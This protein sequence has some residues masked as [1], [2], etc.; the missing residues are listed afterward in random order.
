[1][2]AQQ[3]MANAYQTTDTYSGVT[4]ADPHSLITQMFD[5]AVRKIAQARGA[6][7]RNDVASK[8]E[9]LSQSVAIIGSLEACLDKEK[10]GDLANNLSNLYEYMNISLALANQEND[11]AR[12]DEVIRLIQEIRSAW[13]QIPE[14]VRQE[15]KG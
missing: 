14:E 2:N 4:F 13:T 10:G 5:G 12:L 15:F 11:T 3:N 8:A 7:E 6:I 9:L 1:M